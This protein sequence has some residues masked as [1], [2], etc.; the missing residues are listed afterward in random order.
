MADFSRTGQLRQPPFPRRTWR[1]ILLSPPTAP[2]LM[3]KPK[4]E[5]SWDPPLS[6]P[7]H[8]KWPALWTFHYWAQPLSLS[9]G[10]AMWL[11]EYSFPQFGAEYSTLA[12]TWHR[13]SFPL[14]TAHLVP[15]LVL[16]HHRWIVLRIWNILT[17]SDLTAISYSRWTWLSF[18]VNI[19]KLCATMLLQIRRRGS[20]YMFIKQF[21][22]AN[23]K[24]N[25]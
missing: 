8:V 16:I 6:F 9:L 14:R 13:S 18:S 21:E 15:S 11:S 7:I 5:L 1:N 2:S 19:A 20:L 12:S 23:S 24:Y 3:D 4:R 25:I 22:V 17:F 10:L